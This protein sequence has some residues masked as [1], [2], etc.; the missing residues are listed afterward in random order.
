MLA[1]RMT[2][3]PLLEDKFYSLSLSLDTLTFINVVTVVNCESRLRDSLA[4]PQQWNQ[5]KDPPTMQH[6]GQRCEGTHHSPT[7]LVVISNMETRK[8][9]S[10]RKARTL[11][12]EFNLSDSNE[13]KNIHI[14]DAW[15]TTRACIRCR[16]DLVI[17][18]IHWSYNTSKICGIHEASGINYWMKCDAIANL[19]F[20]TLHISPVGDLVLCDRSCLFINLYMSYAVRMDGKRR[21]VQIQW[22]R[23]THQLHD[24]KNSR[25]WDQVSRGQLETLSNTDCRSSCG[26]INACRITRWSFL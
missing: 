3:F 14:R 2:I 10:G 15:I 17:E 25:P 21:K 24:F 12:N 23:C 7:L 5:L 8:H 13:V 19:R 11:I 22:N 20:D 18:L 16:V 9:L 26:N 4:G 6:H 1:H